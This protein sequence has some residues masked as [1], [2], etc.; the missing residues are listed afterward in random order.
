[1]N[2]SNLTQ[3]QRGDIFWADFPSNQS[4]GSE[5]RGRRPVLVVSVSVINAL[6]ICIIVPLTSQLNKANRHHRIILIE[7]HKIQEPGTQGCRGD[8]LALTEQIRSISRIRLDAQRIA[9]LKP[10]AMAAVEAG[11]K[12]VLGI[13]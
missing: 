4:A 13:F 5:Q 3:P 9:K 10:T 7:S 11:I 12:Y 8:S 6:P 1:M 2:A